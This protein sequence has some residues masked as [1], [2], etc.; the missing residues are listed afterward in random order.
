MLEIL[1]VKRQAVIAGFEKR[2]EKPQIFAQT[3]FEHRAA[4]DVL[5]IFDMQPTLLRRA[6]G[7]RPEPSLY[8]ERLR[9]L[10]RI[11]FDED[12]VINP[13]KPD[14][15]SMLGLDD[16]RLAENLDLVPTDLFEVV[17]FPGG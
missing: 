9:S 3:R 4:F 5:K 11:C 16:R 13:I 8:R 6:V 7:V 10:E 17:E 1:S 12:A 14:R 15:L 2:I